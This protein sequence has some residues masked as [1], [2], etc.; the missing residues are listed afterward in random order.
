MK[1]ATQ[2]EHAATLSEVRPSNHQ[3]GIWDLPIQEGK[4]GDK[5]VQALGHVKSADEQNDRGSPTDTERL[6]EVKRRGGRPRPKLGVD[7]IRNEMDS[8]LTNPK[9]LEKL[10]F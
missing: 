8:H 10:G 7:A 9:P 1:G 4:S 2:P 5:D 6:P 3:D